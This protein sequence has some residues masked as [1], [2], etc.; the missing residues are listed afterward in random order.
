LI[1]RAKALFLAQ[2]EKCKLILVMKKVQ[3]FTVW[4]GCELFYDNRFWFTLEFDRA[5]E[6]FAD[7]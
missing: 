5:D 7:T 1:N 4:D 3:H 2:S 6:V